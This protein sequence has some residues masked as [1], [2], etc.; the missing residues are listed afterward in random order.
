MDIHVDRKNHSD[1]VVR[2]MMA[3]TFGLA[4]DLPATVTTG[5]GL[6]VPLAFTSAEPGH[7]NCRV[8][9]EFAHRQHL[10]LAEQIERLGGMPGSVVTPDKVAAAAALHRELAARYID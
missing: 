7:V 9:R 1:V 2:D 10:D 8:C 3:A 6:E 4:A 5:C